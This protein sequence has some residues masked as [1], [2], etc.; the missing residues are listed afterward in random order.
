MDD[1]LDRDGCRL[2]QAASASLVDV[3][4][5]LQ[6]NAHAG[7]DRRKAAVVTLMAKLTHSENKVPAMC[8]GESGW[9][10]FR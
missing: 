9:T 7:G 8:G 4:T 2:T 1:T 3:H 10:R 6:L 5:T